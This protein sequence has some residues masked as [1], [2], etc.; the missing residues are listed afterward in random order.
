LVDFDRD[1]CPNEVSWCGAST[2]IFTVGFTKKSAGEFFAKLRRPG[3]A[4]VVDV[5]LNNVS[6]VVLFLG[7]TRS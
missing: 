7:S 6:Q 2:K 4:R 1:I 3:P 5:R